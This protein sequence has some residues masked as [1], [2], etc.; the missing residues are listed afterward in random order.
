MMGECEFH[1]PIK[2]EW[3]KD[4]EYEG[5]EVWQ[6]GKCWNR[7]CQAKF[8]RKISWKRPSPTWSVDS[9]TEQKIKSE[10]GKA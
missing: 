2:W 10:A 5:Q 3:P 7:D 4:G 9:A 8:K 6:Y 1:H